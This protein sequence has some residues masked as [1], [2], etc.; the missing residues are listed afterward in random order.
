M[1]GQVRGSRLGSATQATVVI[2][3]IILHLGRPSLL[4][5]L[6]FP[7]ECFIDL[8][9]GAV[10]AVLQLRKWRFCWHP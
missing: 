4:T 7:H 10:I 9:L 6:S 8:T 1:Q 2:I 5:R 3:V